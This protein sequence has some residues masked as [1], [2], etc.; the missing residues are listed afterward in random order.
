MDE[1]QGRRVAMR[2]GVPFIGLLGV[3]V[4]AKQMG[5][6]ASLHEVTAELESVAQFRLTAEIKAIAFKKAGEM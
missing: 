1:T 2:E 5:H 4:Q 3:L 6:I